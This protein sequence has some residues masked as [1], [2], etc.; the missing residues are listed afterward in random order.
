MAATSDERLS[1]FEVAA[2]ILQTASYPSAHA[3][4][5][6]AINV[7]KIDECESIDLA[8]SEDDPRLLLHRDD[9]AIEQEPEGVPTW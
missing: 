9:A 5:Q 1:V 3:W 8:F 7:V 2:R 6:M 4:R